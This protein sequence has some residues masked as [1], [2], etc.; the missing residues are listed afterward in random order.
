MTQDAGS[1]KVG[2][3]G[4]TFNP[5]HLA[6]LVAA[7]DA[8]EL[9]GLDEVWFIPCSAPPHKEHGQLAPGPDRVAMLKLALEGVPWAS[10][11]EIEL[12]RGGISYTVET[13]RELMR[14]HPG[15]RFYF[16]LGT[17]SLVELHQ[18]REIESLLTMC[19]FVSIGRPGW[20]PTRLDEASLR[21]PPPWPG[22][23][24]AQVRTGHLIGVSSTEIR[25]RA[26]RGLSLRY[27]APDAVV[28]YIENKALYRAR[29]TA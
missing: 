3:M 7:Q 20:D 23:L 2:L 18:W 19:T 26:A 17:D 13:L 21:L 29:E 10:V 9:F 1:L 14:L 27:L 11:C 6:H 8:R 25:E 28:Q 15:H 16:I 24:L 4:G 22:R 5:V 12:R